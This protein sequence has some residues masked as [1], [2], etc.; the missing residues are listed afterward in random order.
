MCC[1]K[2]RQDNNKNIQF[3]R[4]RAQ[5]IQIGCYSENNTHPHTKVSIGDPSAQL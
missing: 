5:S 3:D 1:E 2:G 4:K